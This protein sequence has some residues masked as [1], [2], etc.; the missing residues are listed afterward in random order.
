MTMFALPIDAKQAVAGFIMP[1]SRVDVLASVRLQN[2]L[3]ALPILVNM[4]VLAV[5]TNPN[6]PDKGVYANLSTVSFAVNQKQALLIKLAQARGCDI[7][8]L[9]R[10]PEEKENDNDKNYK[11]DDVIKLLQDEHSRA[12]IED[13]NGD[14]KQPSEQPETTTPEGTPSDPSPG[15]RPR[16][17]V[18]RETVTVPYALADIKEN[19]EITEDLIADATVFGTREVPKELAEDAITD[20][21]QFLGKVFKN[22]LGKGQWVTKGLVG[23][24]EPKPAPRSEFTDPKPAPQEDQPTPAA[25]PTVV[26]KTHDV[27]MHTASGTKVFRY[28]EV[29]PGE[30]KYTGEVAPN[31]PPRRVATAQP[32]PERVD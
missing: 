23:K 28:E 22:G 5:D 30:W 1:G 31:T 10:N 13:P 7:S 17:S 12:K 19:T 3:T 14:A 15:P 18:K 25:R 21:K 29:A 27:T 26:R 9:L 11:I 24:A 6:A 8:L 20:L 32:T 16:P 2:K 4:L